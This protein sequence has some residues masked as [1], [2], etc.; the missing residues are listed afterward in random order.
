MTAAYALQ[1]SVGKKGKLKIKIQHYWECVVFVDFVPA[2]YREIKVLCIEK[3]EC[4][5]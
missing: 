4:A 3:H 2:T 1:P 5:E